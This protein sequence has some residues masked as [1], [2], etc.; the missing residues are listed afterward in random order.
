MVALLVMSAST[1]GLAQEPTTEAVPEPAA[2]SAAPALPSRASADA[3][4]KASAAKYA[5]KIQR[6]AITSCNVLIGTETNA[7]AETQAGLG[8]PRGRTEV[9]VTSSYTLQGI[10]ADSLQTLADAIC[11]DAA[12]TMATAGFDVVPSTALNERAEFKQMH[13]GGSPVPYQYERKGA[14][15]TVYAPQGQ[16]LIDP[17]Y[18]SAKA[19]FGLVMSS[20]SGQGPMQQEAM[21]M[22]ALDASAVHLNVM[23]DF[24]KQSSS[25][26][27]GF[28]SKIAGNS[29]A[30][31]ATKVQL[32]LSGLVRFLPLDA[33]TCSG[34]TCYPG[35]V[36]KSPSFVSKDVLIAD[37]NVVVN[38]ANI[39][40]TGE[41]VGQTAVNVLAGAM[42]LSGYSSS[43]VSIERNGVV[44]DPVAYQ[45]AARLKAAEFIG[46][47]AVLSRP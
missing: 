44:V 11:E 17:L 16:S 2:A 42:A 21:L 8:E 26:R 14:T 3:H 33:L 5:A 10:E 32:S 36:G 35:E 34:G 28:L 1:A 46:M 43:M 18:M 27:K 6:V 24:A 13:T 12:A 15:Y 38:V 47:A 4:I 25:N 39:K 30:S 45:Q 23:V 29:E 7:S 41:S 40:T 19:S 22:K 20:M 9:T 37:Q 31:V